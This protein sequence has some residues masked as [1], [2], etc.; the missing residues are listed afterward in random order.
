MTACASVIAFPHISRGIENVQPVF[1]F[2]EQKYPNFP[3][4]TLAPQRGQASC[5]RNNL[6]NYTNL[7][8]HEKGLMTN[9]SGQ[10]RYRVGDYRLIAE[11]K[12]DKVIILILNIG[13]RREVYD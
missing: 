5:L 10:W 6:E 11:I 8:Q 2:A 12:E 7:Q 3:F 9:R 13:H 1:F 4:I